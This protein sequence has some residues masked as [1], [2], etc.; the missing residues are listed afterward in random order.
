[1][2]ACISGDLLR[3]TDIDVFCLPSLGAFS[4]RLAFACAF[5]AFSAALA[6][7]SAARASFSE[8]EATMDAT[9]PSSGRRRARGSDFRADRAARV[10][11]ILR[12][13]PTLL[14]R[15]DMYGFQLVH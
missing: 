12:G 2:I 5:A 11:D 4:G 7:F 14:N 10:G 15:T 1:M 8:T 13:S 6:A 3:K 9:T